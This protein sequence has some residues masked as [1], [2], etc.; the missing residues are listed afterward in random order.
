MNR[1]TRK[2]LS[3]A[4][5]AAVIATAL[6][7]VNG[8]WDSYLT[9]VFSYKYAPE[10]P[11]QNFAAGKI[12]ILKPS[13]RR[14]VLFAAYRYFNGQGFSADE[15]RALVA[16]WNAEFRNEKPEP[17]GGD[18]ILK[19][20]AARRKEV[21]R[22]EKD[23]HTILLDKKIS[24]DGFT[25]F[26]NCT[27]NAFEVATATLGDRIASYGA[28][29]PAVADW[30]AAQDAVFD[31]CADNGTI[32][33][34][35]P[36][37][38]PEWLRKDRSYQI[39]AARFYAMDFD[40]ALDG[41]R[42]IAA[43]FDSVWRETAVYLVGR[44]LVRKASF[45]KDADKRNEIYEQALVQLNQIQSGRFYESARKL[46]NLIKLRTNP[47]NRAR[48]LA[49]SLPGQQPGDQ[50]RQD[51]IDYTWLLDKFETTALKEAEARRSEPLARAA[52]ESMLA[53]FAKIG[54]A[55][56][57]TVEKGRLSLKGTVPANKLTAIKTVLSQSG[58]T[59]LNEQTWTRISDD[60]VVFLGNSIAF[61]N[62][63][64]NSRRQAEAVIRGELLEITVY[65]KTYRR[66]VVS[67]DKTDA[68]IY[69][70]ITGGTDEISEKE[71]AEIKEAIKK[72][73]AERI[74]HQFDSRP[75]ADYEGGYNGDEVLRT[76]F[77][78]NDLLNDELTDW[79]FTFQIQDEAAYDHARERWRETKSNLWL[80]TA[81][82]KAKTNSPGIADILSES[83]KIGADSLI[84]PTLVFHRARL[85][86]EMNRK[87]EAARLLDEVIDSPLDLPVSTRNEFAGLR[88][89]IADNLDSFIKNAVRRPFTF[90]DY[91]QSVSIDDLFAAQKSE[92][93]KD[94]KETKADWDESVDRKLA[95][96]RLWEKRA[97]FDDDSVAIINE[98]FPLTVLIR[99]QKS[100]ALPDYLRERLAIVIWTR[101]VMLDDE[102]SLRAIAPEVLKFAPETAGYIEAKTPAARRRAALFVIFRHPEF[103]PFLQSGYDNGYA[104]FD[105]AY[106]WWCATT[107]YDFDNKGKEIPR[108]A[109]PKPFFLTVAESAAAA[110][111]VKKIK[112]AG[113]GGEFLAE[114]ARLWLKAAPRDQRLPE[115]LFQAARANESYQYGCGNPTEQFELTNLLLTNFPEN[116][117]TNKLPTEN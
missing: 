103:V 65:G 31:N 83:E 6:P 105:K 97:M 21:N 78:P 53:E 5:S 100:P 55:L 73:R 101:A 106:V 111:E 48:E 62:I 12:G 52:R 81:L 46:I 70:Q 9:P 43:D 32:P 88:L 38:A 66:L 17:A 7:T 27:V 60:L 19:K 98:R 39:A 67:P 11:Y 64:E 104:T 57:V 23:T 2:I 63:D 87:T 113:S 109:P 47:A 28:D 84:Y 14:V 13:Y 61:G 114:N 44:T 74:D 96:Y 72:A 10:N 24:T 34:E 99:A 41:F 4:L 89:K 15:Q 102:P 22:D 51:L 93:T 85:L 8:C 40:G 82:T 80:V 3:L 26:P 91:E 79:L 110:A 37:D 95:P 49:N 54:V 1:I 108:A 16:V 75:Q 42:N 77:L 25:Y 68:E 18:D 71:S 90:A 20:W 36:P 107:D 92:W 117:W 86:A 30:L 56:E 112:A 116:E 69:A 59:D 94:Y 35:A 50:L 115:V 29:D 33:P 58:F 76:G 45:T